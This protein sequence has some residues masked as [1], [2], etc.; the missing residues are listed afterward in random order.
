MLV[1]SSDQVHLMNAQ[2]VEERLS[3][4]HLGLS[5][6]PL[7]IPKSNQY[8]FFDVFAPDP[9]KVEDFGEEG[10]V[11]HALEVAFC[12]DSRKSGPIVFKECGTGLDAVVDVLRKYIEKFPYSA[13]LQKWIIDLE[14]A[15]QA[16]QAV[17]AVPR[18]ADV[19]TYCYS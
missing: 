18:S 15:V 4:L 13:V 5:S 6:L 11:N 1:H 19:R 9:E 8:Y 7:S 14:A 3:L 12:P 10:A 2:E 16:V 17:Q